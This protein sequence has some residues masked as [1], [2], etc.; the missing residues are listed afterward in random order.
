MLSLETSFGGDL[1]SEDLAS[2]FNDTSAGTYSE[3]AGSVHRIARG[4]LPLE[5]QEV[6]PTLSE[7]QLL[8]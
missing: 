4:V 5:N 1:P 2:Y 8:V 7:M 3:M 6:C